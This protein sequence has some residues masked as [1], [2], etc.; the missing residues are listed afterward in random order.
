MSTDTDI[1]DGRG[2]RRAPSSIDDVARQSTWLRAYV[3]KLLREGS[4]SEWHTDSDG[5]FPFRWG[6]AACWVAVRS[7]PFLHVWMFAHAAYGLRSTA[8]VLRELNEHNAA[9]MGGRVYLSDGTVTIEQTV[10]VEALNAATLLQACSQVAQT[11]DS[12][13]TLLAAVF[14]GRTP[15]PPDEAAAD[16]EGDDSQDAGHDIGHDAGADPGGEDRDGA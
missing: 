9:L 1:P 13:G 8:A 7:E 5:D 16:D 2:D 15:Y 4:G 12:L 3:E 6:S 10:V 14:G 11:A